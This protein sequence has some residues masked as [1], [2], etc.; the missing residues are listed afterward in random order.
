MNG[1]YENIDRMILISRYPDK[2]FDLVID[3]PPYGIGE[4]G[5]K[6]HT[7]G[8]LAKPK[9]YKGYSELA[10]EFFLGVVLI[11]KIIKNIL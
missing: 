9:N 3:D 5:S 6:N 8:L 4:D 2:Y 1:T 10:S 7:R 11:R